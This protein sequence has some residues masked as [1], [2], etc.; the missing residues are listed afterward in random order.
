MRQISAEYAGNVSPKLRCSGLVCALALAGC[1]GSSH[2][3]TPAVTHSETQQ[4][5]ITVSTTTSS[6]TKQTTARATK[7]TTTT[8]ASSTHTHTPIA[9][10][11]AAGPRGPA[12]FTILASGAISPPL[13]S[14]PVGYRVQLTFDAHGGGASSVVLVAPHPV[15]L[16]VPPTGEASRVVSGLAKGTYPIK[17]NGTTRGALTIGSTPGP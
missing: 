17:V 3:S 15:R 2:S 10:P 8:S 13:I 1:G 16:S 12:T 5:S 11:P 7:T 14:V 9:P 4:T 6:A